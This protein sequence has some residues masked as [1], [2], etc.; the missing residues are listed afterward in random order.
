V[1]YKNPTFMEA[2]MSCCVIS[3]LRASKSWREMLGT[4]AELDMVAS[5]MG[6]LTDCL[7]SWLC[8]LCVWETVGSLLV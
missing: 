5:A 2:S 8:A 6:L 1:T 3:S 4:A 7:K